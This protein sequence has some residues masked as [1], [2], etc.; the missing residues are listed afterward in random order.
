MENTKQIG[1]REHFLN[2]IVAHDYSYQYS[3]DH[4]YW[5]A[6]N[7]SYD[8]LEKNLG[9][10]IQEGENAQELLGECL[11][12]RSEQYKDGLTHNVIRGL[13]EKYLKIEA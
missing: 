2:R 11:K 6:G 12:I 3:D 9:I 4:R 1:T 13:F 8:E 5:S 10:L 7:F